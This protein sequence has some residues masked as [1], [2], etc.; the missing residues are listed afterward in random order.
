LQGVSVRL[1]RQRQRADAVRNEAFVQ[2]GKKIVI[3]PKTSAVAKRPLFVEESDDM[4][5]P[6]VEIPEY[7]EKTYWWA[8]VRPWAIKVF[9]REWL[10][11]LI[12]WFNYS[13]LRD[14]ALAELG[15]RLPGRTI[16][17]SC[18]YGAI[19]PHLYAR[20]TAL[21]GT[22]DVVDVV[23]GQ[24]E[25]LHRKLP[26][27]NK[28]R[29]INMDVSALSL[30]SASYDRVLLF[31]LPH[32]QPRAIR[33]RTFDEAFR[34]VKPGGAVLIVEFSKPRW[35]HPLRYLWLPF[36]AHLEPF[37]PDIW[38]HEDVK[39]WLPARFAER[40]VSRKK[41]FGGYYQTLLFKA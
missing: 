37:A 5:S 18:A 30:A 38:K 6:A 2:H 32:E 27:E 29:L 25:N 26:K 35:W 13:R 3:V 11:N 14:A 1:R 34:I 15:E 4:L 36:L 9:E 23:K 39:A 33:E 21:G 10:I 12:L 8:Y 16:Q 7:L 41:L 28:A 22:L 17:L 19:T 24:L 20:V 40:I 31:F